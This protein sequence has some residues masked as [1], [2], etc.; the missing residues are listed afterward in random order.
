M[1]GDTYVELCKTPK[2]KDNCM[3]GFVIENDR[4]GNYPVFVNNKVP[5]NTVIVGDF[6]QIAV[7]DFEGL[8]LKVDDITYIKK[9]AIQIVA[10]KAFDCVVRRP[11]AFTKLTF[12]A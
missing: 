9:N 5:A 7:A 2:S 11:G 10:I 8:K 1:N 3:A 12:T 4:I 6:G